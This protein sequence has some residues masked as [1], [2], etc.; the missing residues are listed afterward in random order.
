MKIFLSWPLNET[1]PGYGGEAGF[2]SKPVNSISDGKTANTKRFCMSN[3][4]GTHIDAPNHFFPNGKTIDSFSADF[5]VFNKICIL[6]IPCNVGRW[7][8]WGDGFGSIPDDTDLVLVKT[9][10]ES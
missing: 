6:E 9:G 5:W 10:K 4:I 2:A 8:E 3:H 1:T 7:I